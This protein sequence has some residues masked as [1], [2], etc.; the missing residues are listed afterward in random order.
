MMLMRLPRPERRR[1]YQMVGAGLRDP[2]HRA[3]FPDLHSIYE[4]VRVVAPVV[5][6]LGGLGKAR[7]QGKV[8][9]V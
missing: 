9:H 6:Q 7:E 4:S 1:S 3:E 5:E 8:T 2:E